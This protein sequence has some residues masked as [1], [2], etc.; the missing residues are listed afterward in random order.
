T[1]IDLYKAITR[2][3][4]RLL[5][6]HDQQTQKEISQSKQKQM[7]YLSM[8]FLLG[9]LLQMNL[10]NYGL[11]EQTNKCIRQLGLDPERVYEIESDPGLGNGGLG[12]L[13]ACFLDSLAALQLP[14]HGFGIRYH[15]GLFKQKF[16]QG[17]QVELKDEWL[18]EGYAWETKRNEPYQVRMNGHVYLTEK[19]GYLQAVYE[20]CDVVQAI[21]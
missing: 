13:A 7:Y 4:N 3:M 16:V 1:A 19:D 11:L 20:N 9:R 17:N 5:T 8:E 15:Y 21:P 12:R 18:K 10:M 14:G 2:V 6:H